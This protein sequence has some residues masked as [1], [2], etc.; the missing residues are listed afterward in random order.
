MPDSTSDHA[1][2]WAAAERQRELAV[3][4]YVRA[5]DAGDFDTMAEVMT[6]AEVDPELDRLIV[7]VN[8][9]L[10]EEAGLPPLQ[11]QAQLVRALLYQH[12]PSGVQRPDEAVAPLTVGNVAAKLETDHATRTTMAGLSARDRLTNRQLQQSGVILPTP[13]TGRTID[14]LATHLQATASERYWRLFRETAIVLGM[15]RERGQLELAAARRQRKSRTESRN[16][17][18]PVE[19]RR[20]AEGGELTTEATRTSDPG[21][22]ETGTGES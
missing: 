5:F 20:G 14:E 2:Q 16:T 7:D 15:A 18:P 10:H 9:A 22:E 8:A 13:L 19:G 11:E 6:Q 17:A 21:T 3:Y 12:L 4:R 1:S